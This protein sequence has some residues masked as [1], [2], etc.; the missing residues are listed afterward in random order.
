MI[1]LGIETSCDETAAAVCKDGKIASS[2]VSQQIIHSQFGGVV[3]ELASREHEILLNK[4][5]HEAIKEANINL[6]NLNAVAV[7]Q[8]PG[9]NGT[10]LTGICFAKGLGLG[11]NIPVIPINHLEGH[12][13]SNFIAYPSLELPFICLLVSGGH[14]QLWY[15][16]RNW[17]I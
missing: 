8:G 14:T 9:L 13:F 2:V 16:G 6:Q 12:I 1:V 15:V 3:P 11:L 4:V 10:L 5:I 7:T 17:A